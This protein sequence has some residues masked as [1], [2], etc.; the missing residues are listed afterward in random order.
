LAGYAFMTFGLALMLRGTLTDLALAVVLGTIVGA[1]QLRTR[2]IP[3]AYQVFV[4][5]TAAFFVSVVVFVLGRA[6]ADIGV[7]TPLIAPLVTFLPGALLT[8]AVL[9]LATGQMMSGA[10]RLAAGGMQLVLLAIG[11]VTA[12]QLVG[13][14]ATT[15]VDTAPAALSSLSPWV[16]V[17]VFGV[18]VVLARGARRES[19]GWILLILYVAYAGQLIGGLLLGSQL[20]AFIGA[21]AMTPVAMFVALQRDAPPTLVTFLPAFWI[22]V[23]GA[24]GLT[25]VTKYLG[26]ARIDGLASLATAGSTMLGI[27][28]GVLLGI[29]LGTFLGLS[30]AH[31]DRWRIARPPTS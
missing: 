25:G 4:P 30:S 18:G 2:H 31:A 7:F 15:I 3:Q 6:G 8:T 12:A 13:V 16:G 17:A 9:E 26:D 14:P 10:G 11:I 27:S 28:F 22:L 29:M 19:L 1:L 20:S 21:L 24:V 5:V 23:P